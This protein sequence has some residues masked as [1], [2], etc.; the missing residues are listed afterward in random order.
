MS[1]VTEQPEFSARWRKRLAPREGDAGGR[2]R[3]Y[4]P[5]TIILAL[6]AL[7]FTVATIYDVVRQ[8]HISNRLHADLVSWEAITGRHDRHAIIETDAKTYTTRDVVC[9]RT[10]AST[11]SAPAVV[12]LIFQG[13]VA[14]GRR[15]AFGGYYVLK[16]GKRK[17]TVK[18]VARFRYGCFG[19]ATAQGYRCEAAVPPGA[20]DQP[21]LARL[22]PATRRG[23]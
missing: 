3:L 13:P 9:G 23:S 16:T 19:D 8:V 7:V 14:A 5:E 1:T 21:P 4:R 12:C 22:A 10:A 15:H 2:G 17:Q 11:P 20:P 6:V 18:D